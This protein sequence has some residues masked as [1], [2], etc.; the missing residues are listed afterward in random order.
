MN[1]EIEEVMERGCEFCWERSAGKPYGPGD[2]PLA[3][4]FM[5]IISSS[6]VMGDPKEWDWD[7]E[8]FLRGDSQSLE[9]RP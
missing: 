5:A 2:W 7:E 4:E 6:V 3:K 1:Y 9:R 8:S